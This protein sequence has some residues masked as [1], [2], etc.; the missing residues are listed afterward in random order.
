M[1]QR[2]AFIRFVLELLKA[3]TPYRWGGKSLSGIDCS[4]V[5]TLGLYVVTGEDFRSMWNTDR[6]WN[7]WERIAGAQTRPGD[8][9]FYGGGAPDDVSHVMVL[10]DGG[11]VV[12]ASGGDSTT[13]TLE[14]A[15]QQGARVKRYASPLYRP[16][17]R[18]Y[19]RLPL[20]LDGA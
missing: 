13:T 16:D 3:E 1:S 17:I 18:G 14:R 9:V 15:R 20:P 19:R 8:L 6:M 2:A 10:L 5:V 4:G 11:Q 12:G 7:N